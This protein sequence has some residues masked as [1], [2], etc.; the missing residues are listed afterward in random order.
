MD[1]TK[2]KNE[3][4][5]EMTPKNRISNIQNRVQE[6]VPK[7]TQKHKYVQKLHSKAKETNMFK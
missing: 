5:Q 1:P 4:L 2:L 3:Y 7:K 6:M